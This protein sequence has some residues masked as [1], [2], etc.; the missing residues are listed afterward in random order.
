LKFSN[1]YFLSDNL[2]LNMLSNIPF[3]DLLNF[4]FQRPGEYPVLQNLFNCH[5]Q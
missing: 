1:V 2:Q 5:V 3:N 4:N